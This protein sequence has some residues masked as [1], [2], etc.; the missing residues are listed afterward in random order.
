MKVT[1]VRA[2]GR[3]ATRGGAAGS[4]QGDDAI[5]GISAAQ[6]PRFT[7]VQGRVRPVKR[8]LLFLLML[9]VTLAAVPSIASGDS[10][11]ARANTTTYPDS[12]GEDVN[13]PD[14]TNM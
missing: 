5:G 14:I 12:V 7:A 13:A 3:G 4:V 1:R 9:G 8:R 6:T 2:Y 10:A 11:R